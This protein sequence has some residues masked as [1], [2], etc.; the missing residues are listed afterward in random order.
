[1]IWGHAM[2]L[3]SGDQAGAPNGGRFS[4]AIARGFEPSADATTNSA[5][6]FLARTKAS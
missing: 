6:L 5:S 3:P 1:M 4:T 2:E